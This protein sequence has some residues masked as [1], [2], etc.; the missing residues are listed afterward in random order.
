M[1]YT[2]YSLLARISERVLGFDHRLSVKMRCM[3]YDEIDYKHGPSQLAEISA[4]ETGYWNIQAAELYLDGM[5]PY[6]KDKDKK[7]L[8]RPS[9]Y[10]RFQVRKYR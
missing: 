10:K 7:N 6:D 8:L 9:V 5:F 4:Q 1:K 3:I 2:L